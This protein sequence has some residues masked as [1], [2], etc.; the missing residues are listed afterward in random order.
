MCDRRMFHWDSLKINYYFTR[1]AFLIACGN[2]AKIGEVVGRALVNTSFVNS[3][4]VGLRGGGG[5]SCDAGSV[6]I[7]SVVASGAGFV[8]VVGGGVGIVVGG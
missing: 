7:E 5:T 1:N 4:I 8:A 3:I 2:G 6:S